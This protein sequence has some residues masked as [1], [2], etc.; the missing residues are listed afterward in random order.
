MTGRFLPG[1]PW[2]EIEAVFAAAAGNE[3]ATGKFDSPES[4]A[5]LAALLHEYPLRV[6]RRGPHFS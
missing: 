1:V 3:M 2:S 6:G 5:C 4:S